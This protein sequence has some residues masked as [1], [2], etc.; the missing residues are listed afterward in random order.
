M[1]LEFIRTEEYRSLTHLHKK[2]IYQCGNYTIN[3]ITVS[4]E[5]SY[6][7][8]DVINYKNYLPKIYPVYDHDE[9]VTGFSISVRS[10]EF[11]DTEKYE[12]FIS[13]Q[14]EALE[15]VKIL[16]ENFVKSLDI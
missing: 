8:I 3:D 2:D 15:V 11:T 7:R 6:H 5:D 13:A 16:T 14:H 12:E 9:V 10:C 4:G 1:K